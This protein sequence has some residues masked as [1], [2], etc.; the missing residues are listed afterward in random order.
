[1]TSDN[2]SPSAPE[3]TNRQE[4]VPTD[5]GEKRFRDTVQHELL[6]AGVRPDR[7]PIVAERLLTVVTHHHSGPL[8]SVQ[9]FAGYEGVCVGASRDILDMAKRQQQHEHWIGK[10]SVAL[11][12]AGLATA[13]IIIGLMLWTAYLLALQSH[14]WL[15]GLVLTGSVSGLVGIFWQKKDGSS[16]SPQQP[17]SEAARFRPAGRK[18]K[19]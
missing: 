16:A 3:N 11:E 10:A 1:M 17:K 19:K 14:T 5:A 6:S 4:T 8:P 18:R 15:A 12:F 7:A 13:I 2:S 9:D